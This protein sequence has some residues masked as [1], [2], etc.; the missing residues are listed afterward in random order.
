MT[1]TPASNPL[2]G[3]SED[4]LAGLVVRNAGDLAIFVIDVAG[5][6]VS[7]NRGAE[8]ILGWT[9]AE[10]IGRHFEMF[11]LPEDREAGQPQLEMR[12]AAE[13]GTA[14]DARWHVKVDGTWFWASGQLTAMR[15]DDE[16]VGYA[17]VLRDRTEQRQTHQHLQMAQ[18]AGAVGSFELLP[19]NGIIFPSQEFSRLWGV[20]HR[21]Q[22]AVNDFISLIHADDRDK[23][24]TG[25][26]VL[27]A[28]ALDYTEYRIVRPDT[29]EIRWI[30]RRG[31]LVYDEVTKSPRYIGVT[32]DITQRKRTEY[33]LRF[34]AKASIE[35]AGLADRKDTLRRLAFLAVP[36]FSDWCAVDLVQADGT[37]DRV[38]V[39]HVDPAMVQFA[40][41]FHRRFPP[42]PSMKMGVWNVIRTGRSEMISEI[43]DEN[44]KQVVLEPERFNA[45]RKLGFKSYL[46][47]P[48][49]VKGEVIGVV[50]FV[51]AESG[52]RYNQADLSLAEDLGRRVATALENATLYEKLRQADTDK[53]VF[54]A[55][56]AHELR[57]PL[58]AI[59]NGLSV[60]Q[61]AS[62]RKDR[63]E[64]AVK[65]MQRQANQLTRLV[66][67]L[68]DVS[69][70]TTGKIGL[71]KES[72]GNSELCD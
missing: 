63:I 62:D 20:P 57:N 72:G 30:A 50:I 27:P 19:K 23:V 24:V 39:A 26:P 52:R 58:S 14:E 68:M 13:Q 22:C 61:L 45:I 66:D 47:I 67:D 25:N 69:R 36:L 60:L 5:F 31:E 59:T 37:L 10:A 4:R 11:F 40:H 55:T 35:L 18:R 29:K 46:G 41:E 54:L 42:D 49:S 56:L 70:I 3:A 21:D 7:W 34:L 51:S 1:M 43:T 16:L 12:L 71:K 53:D 17:K 6:I 38:A 9:A 33:D 64:H 8:S 28:D 2:S 44:L 15:D 65:L 32:Y 48:L